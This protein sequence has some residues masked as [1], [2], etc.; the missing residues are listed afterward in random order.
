[1]S[2]MARSGSSLVAVSATS[3]RLCG[4][5]SRER[6]FIDL[7]ESTREAVLAVIIWQASI[8]TIAAAAKLVVEKRTAAEQRLAAPL[9]AVPVPPPACCHGASIAPGLAAGA[10][11]RSCV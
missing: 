7:L 1:M 2:V 11:L 6:M 8:R 5:K 9:A 3:P 10:W 4:N